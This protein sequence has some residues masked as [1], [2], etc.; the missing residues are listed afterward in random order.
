MLTRRQVNA[1][2]LCT[3]PWTASVLAQPCHSIAPQAQ[4]AVAGVGA[5]CG[6]G[7]VR[8]HA[9]MPLLLSH[10]DQC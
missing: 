6:M 2:H 1:V 5:G 8:R 3:N 10:A 4:L 9:R 7:A